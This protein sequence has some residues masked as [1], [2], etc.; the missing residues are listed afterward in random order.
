MDIFEDRLNGAQI[1][2]GRKKTSLFPR[3]GQQTNF[4]KTSESDYVGHKLVR[5]RELLIFGRRKQTYSFK[6]N[7]L[8]WI[9]FKTNMKYLKFLQF[10]GIIRSADV[11]QMVLVFQI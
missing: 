8:V 4:S 2:L 10:Y 9:Y 6:N 11:Y 5:G 1:S 3:G 7:L